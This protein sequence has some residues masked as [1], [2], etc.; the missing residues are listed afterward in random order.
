MKRG[1]LLRY[2]GLGILFWG[3]LSASG[4]AQPQSDTSYLAIDLAY[5]TVPPVVEQFNI[6]GG[7]TAQPSGIEPS[8]FIVW[9]DQLTGMYG[10]TMMTLN[11]AT[12]AQKGQRLIS[13]LP[14]GVTP[15]DAIW[16]QQFSSATKSLGI[17][18]SPWIICTDYTLF[19]F[20]VTF[21]PDGTPVAGMLVTVTPSGDPGLNGNATCMTEIPGSEFPDGLPRLFVG[22]DQGKIVVLVKPVGAGITVDGVISSIGTGVVVDVEPIPQYGYIALGVLKSNKIYGIHYAPGNPVNTFSLVDARTEA[23][24]HFD[25]FGDDGVPLG[26]P[27]GTV[28]LILANGSTTLALATVGGSLSGQ[29]YPSLTSNLVRNSIRSVVAGSMLML[30]TDESNVD[31]DIDFAADSGFSGCEV[32]LTDAVADICGYVC[33]DANGDR[34]VNVADAVMLINRIFKSGPEPNP[35]EAGNANCDAGLN[36]ADAVYM[37]TYVFKSGPKPC[38]P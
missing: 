30:R 7:I 10:V 14:G 11:A 25:S 27:G 32:T 29:Q 19:T 18:P 8:P 24:T 23:T 1:L 15:V 12:G 33:G 20:P 26:D 6:A 21:N 9:R 5:V 35:P 2:I 31:V 4:H 3:L 37:I 38:C 28:R 22:T 34:S 13:P 16:G 17:E 36:V